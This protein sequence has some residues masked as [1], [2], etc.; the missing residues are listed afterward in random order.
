MSTDAI[1]DFWP[2]LRERITRFR[3]E[4]DD[5]P[6]L[7]EVHAREI[8]SYLA[9]RYALEEPLA[10][11]AII[12]D[13]AGML[14]R[15]QVLVGHRRYFGL[16]NPDTLPITIAADALAAAFNPQIAAWS[17]SPAAAEVET[18]TLNALL[19]KIG[20]PIESAS[21]SFTS[22]G[23]EANH[24]GALVALTHQF[25][26]FADEG[27]LACGGQPVFYISREAHHSFIKI[28][29][30]C[31]VGRTAVREIQP[32]PDLRL[33]AGTIRE[34]IR[35]DRA[36]G[37]RPF[38]VVATAGTTGAGIVDPLPDLAQ[39]CRE[40]CLW[41]H[42][43]AAW[44]GG[45]LLSR[46]LRGELAG[47]ELADSI[48]WDAHKWLSVPMGAGMFFCRHRA[49][50]QRAFGVQ[51]PYMPAP[52]DSP[53]PYRNSMQWSRRA[54]GLKVFMA[55]ASLGWDGYEQLIDHQAAMGDLLREVAAAA[56]WQ[57]VNPATRL[58]VVCLTHLRVLS[59]QISVAEIIRRVYAKRDVWVSEVT[60]AGI[61][62][63]VRACITCYR[64][65]PEDIRYLVDA[66]NRALHV[67]DHD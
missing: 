1:D 22:G 59:G 62:S 28:A 29:H 66:L 30:A 10:A 6:V 39:L 14:A 23:A 47:I 51:T 19:G 37:R 35:V 50:V 45:A 5:G 54:T 60:L 63:A 32:G 56:G 2:P 67:E 34:R 7:P 33:D 21:A 65:G 24:S 16:F 61:G 26:E 25:S 36:E 4:M 42:V 11:S 13:V 31:G 64:T 38:M 12:D 15:W 44:G 27:V 17:H 9:E 18:F 20:F 46:K 53:D 49:A 41:L 8:Q 43:D 55:L 52:A 48:T 40:E 58:P 57:I 3:A